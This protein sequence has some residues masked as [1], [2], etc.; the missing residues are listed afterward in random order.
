MAETQGAQGPTGRFG[1]QV[2]QS[3]QYLTFNNAGEMK[4]NGMVPRSR[5]HL[6]SGYPGIRKRFQW[7]NE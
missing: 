2:I 7:V 1:P 6:N 3:T 4:I 5:Y